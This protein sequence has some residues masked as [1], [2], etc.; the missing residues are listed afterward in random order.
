MGR[1]SRSLLC[2]HRH[3]WHQAMV[4]FS[5]IE[6]FPLSCSLLF[7]RFLS[8]AEPILSRRSLL[9]AFVFLCSVS[10]FGGDQFRPDQSAALT[11]FFSIFCEYIFPLFD[12]S[13]VSLVPLLWMKRVVSNLLLVS[14]LLLFL[15]NTL[16]TTRYL[17]LVQIC[18]STVA[19]LS[20]HLSHQFCASLRATS[21]LSAFPR[22]CF[23]LP[24]AFSIRKFVSSS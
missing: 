23:S 16:Q 15:Q 4:R 5:L 20:P 11:T 19:L 17:L 8:L 14:T 9:N 13:V 7:L 6:L 21:L 3:G 1:C 12:I 2:G 10:S 18:A 22:S 24:Q